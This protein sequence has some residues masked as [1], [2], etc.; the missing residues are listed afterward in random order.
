MGARVGPR[1]SVGKG[2]GTL[3]ARSARARGF[4]RAL[5]EPEPLP[6]PTPQRF[7]AE[8]AG[9][10]AFDEGVEHIATEAVGG[11]RIQTCAFDPGAQR[12]GRDGAPG[13]PADHR[14]GRQDVRFCEVAHTPRPYS[15]ART[16]P[17]DKQMPSPGVL[18]S[19]TPRSRLHAVRPRHPQTAS[20]DSGAV[21]ERLD[22]NC[23]LRTFA[24]YR[25]MHDVASLM[26]LADQGDRREYPRQARRVAPTKTAARSLP[27]ALNRLESGDA[28]HLVLTTRNVPRAVLHHGRAL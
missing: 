20:R 12:T 21:D 15:A 6:G 4:S 8:I 11:Q 25:P 24:S 16:P 9:R 13:D 14:G 10:N 2:R 26:Y 23:A 7:V 28:E 3:R 5:S 1:G 17:P 27:Q 22:G 19:L 18:S